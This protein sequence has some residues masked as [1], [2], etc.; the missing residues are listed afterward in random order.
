MK[1]LSLFVKT[2]GKPTEGEENG[3]NSDSTTQTN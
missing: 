2:K 1:R 3:E